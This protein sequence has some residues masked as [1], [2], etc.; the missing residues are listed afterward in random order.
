MNI[1]ITGATSDIG[2][3]ICRELYDQGHSIIMSDWSEDLLL[4]Y[5]KPFDVKRCRILPLDLSNANQISV[6]IDQLIT[7][8]EFNINCIV[9]AAGIFRPSPI[10]MFDYTAAK[11]EFDVSFFSAVE[12]LRTLISK[13]T[14]KDN[15]KSVVFISSVSAKVGTKGYSIYGAIKSA[16]LG[17]V[18]SAALEL[19]P[20][21]RINSVLPGGIRTKAT[22]F[23]YNATDMSQIYPLGEGNPSNIADAVSFLLS[24]KASWITGQE[25]VVDGG[26]TI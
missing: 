19:A 23:I 4:D 18:K 10:R 5:Q 2:K 25:L 13:K 11:K 7:N 21:I 20:N 12:I 6:K 1:L 17:F 16:I 15:L 3:S 9:F 22:E 8:E 14:Y 26:L 24:D